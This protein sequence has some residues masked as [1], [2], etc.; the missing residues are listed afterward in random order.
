MQNAAITTEGGV[1]LRT[2]GIVISQGTGGGLVF[3]NR[4]GSS[5]AHVAPH[6]L[7]DLLHFFERNKTTS[8]TTSQHAPNLTTWGRNFGYLNSSIHQRCLK[9]GQEWSEPEHE[10]EQCRSCHASHIDIDAE[11][12]S[13]ELTVLS[14]KGAGKGFYILPDGNLDAI[15]VRIY[16]P[17]LDHILPMLHAMLNIVE[18]DAEQ[19]STCCSS[20][21]SIT[22][23][24]I[25]PKDKNDSDVTHVPIE[26]QAW[27]W[28]D[29]KLSAI[30]DRYGDF[31][32]LIFKITILAVAIAFVAAKITDEWWILTIVIGICSVPWI[33][34]A[35]AIIPQFILAPYYCTFDYLW[36]HGIDRG[37]SR[38][39]AFFVEVGAAATV[40]L[41]ITMGDG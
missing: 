40:I 33:L 26:H 10:R 27:K 9:C 15:E 7:V 22:N 4:D 25:K 34:A 8:T 38:T 37:A 3:S 6:Q 1:F 18:P 32:T 11:L 13:Q 17:D 2:G 20:E 29:E 28:I 31:V 41:I 16:E 23:A 39:I 21:E 14:R 24:S 35:L 19:K 5:S 30:G 36:R 12:H